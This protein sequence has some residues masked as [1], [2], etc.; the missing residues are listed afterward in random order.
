MVDIEINL[1]KTETMVVRLFKGRSLM[2]EPLKFGP[3]KQILKLLDS[4][5][6]TQY[7]GVWIRA[8]DKNETVLKIIGSDIEAV[9]AVIKK[10]HI[11]E[12]Q[13]IYIFNSVLSPTI[14]FRSQL[15]H[16]PNSWAKKWT[17]KILATV[18]KKAKLSVNFPASAM[19]H[20]FLYNLFKIDDIQA[21]GKITDLLVRLN[22]ADIAGMATKIRLANLQA[23][24]WSAYSILEYPTNE[25][26]KPEVN[27][28]A[29]IIQ[30]IE[31]R[32]ISFKSNGNTHGI[33]ESSRPQTYLIE[34]ILPS[35]ETYIKVRS[36]LRKKNMLYLHQIQN[37][38]ESL[39]TWMDFTK[40]YKQSDSGRIP[41]WFKIL[42]STIII[43]EY[44]NIDIAQCE[45]LSMHILTNQIPDELETMQRDT[46]YIHIPDTLLSQWKCV[47]EKLK[48]R[49]EIEIS[50][51]NLLVKAG[52]E[53]ARR[54]AAFI[55]HGI[56]AEF[57][58]AIDG[59][60][61]STKV[62]TKVVLLAL[63]A[64][65]YRC[66]LTINTDSQVVMTTAQRWL[67]K[68]YSLSIRNQLK[69]PNWCTWNA[70]R[71]IIREKRIDLS[72]NKVAAHAGILENE[73]AD[74]LAK[75]STVLNTMRWAYNAKKAA[76]IPVCGEVELDLNIRHFL[77]KQA[78]LQS[79]LD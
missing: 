20:S 76:Y 22:S 64:V 61:S 5:T 27:F 29:N 65:P 68:N 72:M 79:A 56:E 15:T 40:K 78:R 41:K 47:Q 33:P 62:E 42:E 48:L 16:I 6:C 51:D 54:A 11:T 44:R 66:K 32:G 70:I 19:H 69:T 36:L 39:M 3:D 37:N 52:S 58:I 45:T 1:D 75:K 13:A 12:K 59:T 38:N 17:S 8:D 7:L 9:C 18:K 34:S 57:G 2:V 24:R 46:I 77:N 35:N 60:L 74:K 50:T 25:Q 31:K 21:K 10:K 14:E 28:I 53:E 63:E 55:I 49:K 30:M 73:K 4:F 67:S 26:S 43:D 71:A 23:Q